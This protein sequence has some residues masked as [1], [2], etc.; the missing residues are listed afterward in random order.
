MIKT[1]Q[2]TDW[3]EDIHLWR[4]AWRK[5]KGNNPDLG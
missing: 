5:E 1:A 4:N 2:I 3:A